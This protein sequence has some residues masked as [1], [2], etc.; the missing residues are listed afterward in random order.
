MLRELTGIAGYYSHLQAQRATKAGKS[1]SFKPRPL[2][3]EVK[4]RRSDRGDVL[5]G[6][7]PPP[8]D[9]AKAPR[10]CFAKAAALDD[11]FRGL[12][13]KQICMGTRAG[14]IQLAVIHPVNQQPVWGKVAFLEPGPVACKLMVAV[15][16]RQ[17]SRNK[18]SVDSILQKSQ[19]VPPLYAL[20]T[21]P[22][23]LGATVQLKHPPRPRCPAWRKTPPRSPGSAVPRLCGSFCSLPP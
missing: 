22:P 7:D 15:L 3:P 20:A 1:F 12:F 9:N 2:C 19:I 4:T 11:I 5:S 13:P 14:Q 6:A 18:Q 8:D 10:P 21:I 17:C 16:P 23:K